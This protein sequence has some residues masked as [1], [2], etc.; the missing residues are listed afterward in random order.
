MKNAQVSSLSILEVLE[1]KIV[2]NL[3]ATNQT[4]MSILKRI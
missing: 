3:L 2:E 4:Q 1:L